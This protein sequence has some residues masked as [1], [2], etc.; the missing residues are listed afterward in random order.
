MRG[1]TPNTSDRVDPSAA[2]YNAQVKAQ[3]DAVAGLS[4]DQLDMSTGGM[5]MSGA[6]ARDRMDMMRGAKAAQDY[7]SANQDPGM[8]S[9][10]MD[11]LSS[12][13][14]G[15]LGRSAANA[16]GNSLPGLGEG[17]SRTAL[18][19][20][21]AAG[22]L[23][24]PSVGGMARSALNA[25]TSPVLGGINSLGELINSL[26]SSQQASA[27]PTPT[28]GGASPVPASQQDAS[29][30][31]QS[32]MGALA[33][34]R[35]ALQPG[36]GASAAPGGSGLMNTIGSALNDA[37]GAASNFLRAAP[38]ALRD[39]AGA[40]PS[41]LAAAPGAIRDLMQSLGG[42]AVSAFGGG[43]PGAS[44]GSL[45]RGGGSA[46]LGL[47]AGASMGGATPLTAAGGALANMQN[48]VAAA[49]GAPQLPPQTA[50][51]VKALTAGG[52]APAA[53][54]AY[55]APQ[56]PA[57][58]QG[59]QGGAFTQRMNA[60]LNAPS[61]APVA[62]ITPAAVGAARGPG[63]AA[64]AGPAPGAYVAPK[65]VTPAP[66]IPV[67]PA[68]TAAAKA[69]QPNPDGPLA[70]SPPQA[71]QST[72]A[73]NGFHIS[74]RTWNTIIDIGAGLMAHADRPGLMPFGLALQ[75][76]TKNMNA[77][78]AASVTHA[79]ELKKINAQIAQAQASLAVTA[80]NHLLTHADKEA[81]MAQNAE[82][83]RERM[84]N[85]QILMGMGLGTK[86][87]LA[88]A[89]L[90]RSAA[91]TTNAQTAQTNAQTA[92]SAEFD[93]A[94]SQSRENLKMI[95]GGAAGLTAEQLRV[96]TMVPLAAQYGSRADV[97]EAMKIRSDMDE[98]TKASILPSAGAQ[99][100]NPADVNVLRAKYLLPPISLTGP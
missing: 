28:P 51:A 50:A 44:T 7:A 92:A 70:G 72:L 99:R 1:N 23:N 6:P 94:L 11:S 59:P 79:I 55:N 4:P 9:R 76:A 64:S 81:L 91:A 67:T 45:V 22:N 86:Q 46:P 41:A 34:A 93:K 77:Q 29:L 74:G 68:S 36:G 17:V 89:A 2:A 78:D 58:P 84:A 53:A 61:A 47:P 54:Q 31:D 96:Q 42:Q 60:P 98:T 26:M 21:D 39:A 97:Q 57:G 19:A 62:P 69:G 82:L 90:E 83:A 80:Q 95:P 73:S 3:N 13:P 56:G 24:A 8:M 20:L 15:L 5:D 52:G 63:P 43:A 40:A 30:M 32:G 33:Q 35:L 85:Q 18:S 16:A 48:I 27:A 12:S 65:P 10:L 14:L 49:R 87:D 66:D 71:V 25:G 38:G 100:R 37:G 75:D 88:T